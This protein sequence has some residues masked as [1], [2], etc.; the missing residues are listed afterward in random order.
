MSP[1][2]VLAAAPFTLIVLVAVILLLTCRILARAS[3]LRLPRHWNRAL[4]GVTLGLLALFALLVVV[5]FLTLA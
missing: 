2:D 4:N 3:G 1:A 5:R